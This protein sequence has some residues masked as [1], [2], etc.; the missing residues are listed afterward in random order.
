MPEDQIIPMPCK[1]HHADH[2]FGLPTHY[3]GRGINGPLTY[4]TR[5]GLR[6]KEDTISLCTT[7][8]CHATGN[9]RINCPVAN[10]LLQ[11]AVSWGVEVPVTACIQFEERPE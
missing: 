7:C 1:E 8:R 5:E 3:M 11:I 9:P 6:G 2:E 10:L 4:Y